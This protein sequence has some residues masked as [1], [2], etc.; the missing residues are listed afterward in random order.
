MSHSV[1]VKF[2]EFIDDEQNGK[3]LHLDNV[4]KSVDQWQS[5]CVYV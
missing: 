3:S 5:D 2:V 4:Y 1:F